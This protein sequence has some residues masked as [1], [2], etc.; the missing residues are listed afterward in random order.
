MQECAN[1]ADLLYDIYGGLSRPN[2]C[3]A[4]RAYLAALVETSEVSEDLGS[5]KRFAEALPDLEQPVTGGVP[6][7]GAALRWRPGERSRR[8]PDDATTTR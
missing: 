5:L 7:G 2:L 1:Y 3:D 8:Q 4:A 6:S